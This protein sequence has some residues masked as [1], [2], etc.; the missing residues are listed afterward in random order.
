MK[1]RTILLSGLLLSLVT[2]VLGLQSVPVATA[3]EG[4]VPV[5]SAADGEGKAAPVKGSVSK[6]KYFFKKTCK[7]C[8]AKDAEGGEVTPMSKTIKQWERYFEK[9]DHHGEQ[10]LSKT[11]DAEQ[12]LH[13]QTFLINHAADSDQPETC[14]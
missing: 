1:V 3:D 13:I 8:H 4:D 14:G 12:L 7:S 2:L 9:D 10:T 5:V 11:F 6:G